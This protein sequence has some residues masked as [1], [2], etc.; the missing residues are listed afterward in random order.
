MVS[1]KLVTEQLQR[2]FPFV[3]IMSEISLE[4]ILLIHEW[5]ILT[6]FASQGNWTTSVLVS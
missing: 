2:K 4:Y 1:C 3:S 5:F 6:R